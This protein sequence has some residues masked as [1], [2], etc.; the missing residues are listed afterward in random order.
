M[1]YRSLVYNKEDIN[2]LYTIYNKLNDIDNAEGVTNI[3]TNYI[4]VYLFIY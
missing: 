4:N 3:R 2:T 1:N